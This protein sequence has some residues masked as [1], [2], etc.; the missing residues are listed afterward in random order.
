MPTE[1]AAMK[2]M[3][4]EGKLTPTGLVVSALRSFGK[5]HVPQEKLERLRRDLSEKDRRT[6]LRE[7][8]LAPTWMHPH[9]RYLATGGNNP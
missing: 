1:T 3:S 6:L 7:L 8:P 9:L 2:V 4:S 5:G